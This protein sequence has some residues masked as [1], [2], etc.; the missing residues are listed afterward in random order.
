[1]N[2]IFKIIIFGFLMWVV[3]FLV[4]VLIY[5]LK[6]SVNPFFES[7]MPVVI[8]VIVVL[9]SIKYF[10]NINANFLKEGILMGITWFL[11]SILLDLSLFMWGPMQMS[12]VNYIMDIGT[13]YIIIPVVTIGFG[14]IQSH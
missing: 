13:T 14:Y 1:M 12:F 9:L 6:T 10:T 2:K 4:S 11:I 5:P 3:P 8:T 7:I